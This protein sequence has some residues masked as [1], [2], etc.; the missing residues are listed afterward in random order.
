MAQ[1]QKDQRVLVYDPE[2]ESNTL[3]INEFRAYIKDAKFI[4]NYS[5]LEI[6]GYFKEIRWM[7][8]TDEKL[9][10]QIQE[11]NRRQRKIIAK[12]ENYI[13]YDYWSED[14]IAQLTKP[15]S[16][17]KRIVILVIFTLL[18][19]I[20]LLIIIGLNKWW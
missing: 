2:H 14:P 17:T 11:A 4:K 8:A 19:V 7:Q 18:F 5:E 9:E 20:M 15:L 10:S 1:K 16:K 3:L 13:E 6:F 12:Y